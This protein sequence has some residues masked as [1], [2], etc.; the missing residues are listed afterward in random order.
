MVLK[1]NVGSSR[2]GGHKEYLLSLFPDSSDNLRDQSDQGKG[3]K[4]KPGP[5]MGQRIPVP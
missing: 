1:A 3:I 4:E 5:I 2:A